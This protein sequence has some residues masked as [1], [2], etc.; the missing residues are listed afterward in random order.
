[1]IYEEADFSHPV[2]LSE[3]D[4]GDTI[5]WEDNNSILYYSSSSHV[6]ELFFS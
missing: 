3:L 2:W 1:M 5:H 6:K 4:Q